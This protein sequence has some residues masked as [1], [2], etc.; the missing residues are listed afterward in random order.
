MGR[1]LLA[2]FEEA[3]ASRG[4]TALRLS[5]EASL[6]GCTNASVFE[7]VRLVEGSWIMREGTH[8]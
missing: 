2:A 4:V 8:R 1:R 3:A 7:R 5:V 6:S